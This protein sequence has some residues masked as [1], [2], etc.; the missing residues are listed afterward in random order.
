MIKKGHQLFPSL[1]SKVVMNYFMLLLQR[2]ST[3]WRGRKNKFNVIPS[4]FIKF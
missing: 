4:K 3:K 1:K 2:H